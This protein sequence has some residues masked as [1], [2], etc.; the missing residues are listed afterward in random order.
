ME[1]AEW[2][3]LPAAAEMVAKSIAQEKENGHL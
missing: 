3:L 1:Q 2:L